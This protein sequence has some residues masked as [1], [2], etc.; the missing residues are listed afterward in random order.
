VQT[1]GKKLKR[2]SVGTDTQE[3]EKKRAVAEQPDEGVR[4]IAMN[5]SAGPST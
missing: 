4:Q 5:Q 1:K 2:R 3:N